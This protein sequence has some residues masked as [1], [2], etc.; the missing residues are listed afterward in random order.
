MIKVENIYPPYKNEEER[1]EKIQ[2]AYTGI[3]KMLYNSKRNS[4]S[5][6]EQMKNV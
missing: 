4:K 5:K 2:E 6:K 1:K 3:Q